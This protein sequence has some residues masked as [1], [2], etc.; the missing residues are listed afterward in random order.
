[1]SPPMHA[2]QRTRT[3]SEDWLAWLP[4]EM[5]QLFDSTR[6]DMESSCVILNVTLDDALASCRSGRYGFAS[7]QAAIFTDLFDR[8]AGRLLLVIATIEGH[9]SH[10]CTLPNVAPLAP[11][12]FRGAPAQRIARMNALLSVVLFRARTRFF[13]KLHALAEIIEELQARAR[14]IS[15]QMSDQAGDDDSAQ[16]AGAWREMEV[17][18]YDLNTCMGEATVVLKSFFCALPPQELEPFRRRLLG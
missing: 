16:I 3:V 2:G 1:M 18:G 6:D 11:G 15:D 14:G 10:F 4:A 13:H 12:N 5:D 17:L 9:G 7:K 8:L